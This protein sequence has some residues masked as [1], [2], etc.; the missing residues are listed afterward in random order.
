MVDGFE[1]DPAKDLINRIKHGV[2][3]ETAKKAF[4]DPA[5]LIIRDEK[6]DLPGERRFFCIGRVDGIVVT[7]RFTERKNTIR[8]FGAAEWRKGRKRYE[9]ETEI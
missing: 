2:S 1:W 4:E 5:K 3:F 9:T 6:H 8:I 7:V